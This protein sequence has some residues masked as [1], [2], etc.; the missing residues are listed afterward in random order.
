MTPPLPPETVHIAFEP[1]PY[2]MQ[3]GLVAQDPLDLVEID[4]HYPAELAERRRLLAERHAEVFA[5]EPGSEAACADVLAHL[6]S[7]LPA[8]YPGWFSRH[9]AILRNHLT[10][11]DWNLAAPGR[12]PLEVA[13][14]LVQD[15]LCVVQ[16]GAG[17]PILTAAAL[18]FPS[19]WRLAEKIGRPLAQVHA[20]VPIYPERLA[21]PV[22]RLMGRLVPGKL[23]QR[24]NWSLMDDPTLFQPIRRS[25]QEADASI[26]PDNAGERLFLR[27]ERQTLAAL[28]PSGAVLF[29]I[30]VHVYPLA[31]IAAVPA[32]AAQL[33]EAVRALPDEVRYHKRLGGFEAALL[34]YLDA[35]AEAV[36]TRLAIA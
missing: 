8:R 4:E 12:H 23:V 24:L 5:A 26:T 28:V 21:N 32:L 11:E 34:A 6:A 1:G 30:R 22:D 36:E 33:A 35:R 10:G 18:C 14:L 3:M 25:P 13:A 19:R 27:T 15:D 2:R 20:P 9:G 29:T 17:G 31:R 16:P 7:V